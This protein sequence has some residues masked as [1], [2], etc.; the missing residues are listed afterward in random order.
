MISV[1]NV[2]SIYRPDFG[3]MMEQRREE[4]KELRKNGIPIN[5]TIRYSEN[6]KVY[7]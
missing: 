1:N 4:I 2:F 5:R 3:K 7:N 6:Y